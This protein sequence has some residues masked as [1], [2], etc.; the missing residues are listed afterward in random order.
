MMK[1]ITQF[2]SQ[3]YN[4]RTLPVSG[5]IIHYTEEEL[6]DAIRI[7]ADEKRVKRVSAHYVLNRNGDVF[8]VVPEEK[9]AW[10]AGFGSWKG[11][12][13]LNSATIG[14]EL[15]Y[16]PGEEYQIPQIYSLIDLCHSVMSHHDIKWVIGHSDCAFARGKVDP[17]PRFPWKELAQAGI[18]IWPDGS[19]CK[20]R[21][22]NGELLSRIGYDVTDVNSAIGAFS[23]HFCPWLNRQSGTW[24]QEFRSCVES[25]YAVV[26]KREVGCV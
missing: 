24:E 6:E 2:T 15:V 13:D 22:E 20:S 9:R 14:V 19:L 5:I 18:G 8:A 21:L 4:E 11:I 23:L 10:H 17:G 1:V 3:N 25:V 12:N 26:I 7:F 16:K